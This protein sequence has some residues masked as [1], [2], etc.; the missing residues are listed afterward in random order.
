MEQLISAG[1]RSVVMFMVFISIAGAILIFSTI[2]FI[3]KCLVNEYTPMELKRFSII[4]TIGLIMLIP[5]YQSFKSSKNYSQQTEAIAQKVIAKYYPD[6]TNF[7]YF[8]D[9]GSF[10]NNE[11][12]YGIYY[13]K[14]VSNKEY[15]IVSII[16]RDNTRGKEV[17][18]CNIPKKWIG[19]KNNGTIN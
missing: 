16:N 10:E 17:N 9:E 7:S 14:T 13:K 12:K 1:T 5:S 4:F 11:V 18:K 19:E 15:F 3:I 6:A 8:L 2:A